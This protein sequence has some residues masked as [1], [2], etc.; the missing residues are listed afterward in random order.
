MDDTKIELEVLQHEVQRKLGRCMLRLQQYERLL[1]AM[2][3]GI[4]VEGPVEQLHATRARREAGVSDKSLGTLLRMFIGSHLTLASSPGAADPG[5]ASAGDK[6]S[7]VPWAS[8]RFNISMS[9]EGHAQTKAGLAELVALR[10]ELVHHFIDRFD[11]SDES[12]CRGA[13]IH[14]DGCYEQIDSHCKILRNWANS[15]AKSQ[16]LALS[17]VQSRAFE[18]AVVHGINPDGSVAGRGRR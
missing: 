13:S 7:E 6:S 14:L 15:V 9:P 2:V 17:Y 18:D 10:N 12:S 3:A 5:H 16:A 11:I 4:A 1:K 8:V